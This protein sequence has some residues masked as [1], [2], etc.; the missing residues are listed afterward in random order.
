MPNLDTPIQYVKGVGPHRASLL[1]K[2]GISTVKDALFYLPLRYEDRRKITKLRFISP[3][4]IATAIGRVHKIE[5]ISRYSQTQKKEIKITEL[6]ISDSSG[7]LKAVWFNQP[8]MQKVFTV[9]QDVILHGAVK[10]GYKGGPFVMNSPDYEILNS[11][12]DDTDSLLHTGRIV[13]VYGLTEGLS[14]KV[15]RSLQYSIISQYAQAL[16]DTLPLQFVPSNLPDLKTS[17]INLHFPESHVDCA[18]LNSANSPFHHRLAYEELFMLQVGLAVL[19]SRCKIEKGIPFNTN[20]HLVSTLLR[21]LPFSLTAAQNRV[22]NEIFSDMQKPVA[23]HRLLQGDVGAGKTIVALLAMLASVDSGYQS[24]LMAPT[25]ILAWQHYQNIQNLLKDLPVE[26]CLIS[27][28]VKDKNYQAIATGKAHIVVGTHALIQDAVD[29]YNLGLVVIDE[30][31]RFGVMQRVALRKKGTNPDVLVM[32]AT[33]IPRT[34]AMTLYGDLDYSVIDELP[35]N[36]KPITTLLFYEKQKQKA[37]DILLEQISKGHQ[38]YIVYPLIEESER[39]KLKSAL[40]GAEGFKKKF[41]HLRVEVLHG[42]LRQEHRDKIMTM[43]KNKELDVLI[44]TTVIEVG[45]DVPNA[46]V[47][48]ITNAERF[49][50]SQL[51]QLRGRVGRGT[52]QSYCILICYGASKEAIHRLKV[53]TK[54]NDGFKIAEEDLLLRGPG[55]FFGTRQSGMPELRFVN[56]TQHAQILQE[57]KDNAFRLISADEQLHGFPQFK[58]SLEEFWAGKIEL[59]KT[60]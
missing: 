34:L 21:S 1:A 19:K 43:F 38:A 20:G 56:L 50:L 9:G 39:L 31:H 25:E 3:H 23:M 26:V 28:S 46:S 49:G 33:P 42:Q 2:L 57:A 45:V 53:M 17:I 18:I 13:P 51:H 52:A 7:F 59:F 44:S 54:T 37:Y 15:M 41:P 24:A 29:F 14:Q 5:T 60:A 35:P 30:Q 55:E 32:T 36:R 48:I 11:D 16:Q 40:Q 10:Y 27:S 47:M 8:Y 12:A 22:I 6:V 4:T 58:K